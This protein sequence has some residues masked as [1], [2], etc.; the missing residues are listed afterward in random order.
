MQFSSLFPSTLSRTALAVGMVV[1]LAGCAAT[2][3]GAVDTSGATRLQGELTSSS[4]VNLNDGSQYQVFNLKLKAGELVRVEQ[5]GALEGAVLTLLD[6]RNQLVSGPRHGSLHLAPQADGT[7]RLGVSGSTASA[8]GPFDLT[9]ERV[10]PRNSGALELNDSVFGL[11]SRGNDANTYTLTVAEAGLYEIALGSEELDTVLKLNGGGL[12]LEDD[13]GGDGTN[14]RMTVMLDPGTY[15]VTATAL[16]S[17]AEGGYD[18]SLSSRALPEGVELVNGGEIALGTTISGLA[19]S[20]DK[21][22]TLAVPERSLLRIVMSSD[23]VDSFLK[24]QGPGVDTS[25]DDGAGRDLDAAITTLANPGSYRISA[26]TVDG[27]AGIF[28]LSTAVQPVSSNSAQVRP[29]E[30][31]SGT[32]AGNSVDKTLVIAEAGQYKV[33]MYATE[34]DALLRMSGNGVELEDDD[35]AGGTNSR[36]STYLE[37]GRYTL[38]ARSYDNTGRGSF[39]ISVERE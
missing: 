1:T 10:T 6:S 3:G 34:F 21:V 35:G 30:G 33:D 8:Y 39:V 17:P 25:D 2:Q 16:D 5:G 31:V 22:Y 27:S 15:Q 37:P 13:D 26:S 29:G 38:S 36:I 14:S 32:L 18:L 12:S 24:L 20:S 9:L 11:L 4:P 19:D 7:Y 23:E 28:T